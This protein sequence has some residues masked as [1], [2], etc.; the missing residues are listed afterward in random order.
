MVPLAIAHTVGESDWQQ[1]RFG[2]YTPAFSTLAFAPPVLDCTVMSLFARAKCFR[3]CGFASG[4]VTAGG[5]PCRLRR[6][7]GVTIR[8]N[9]PGAQVYVDDYEISARAGDNRNTPITAYGK[10]GW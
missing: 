6:A 3:R 7:A 4:R 9:P 5:M 2:R 1:F 10:S 8:S